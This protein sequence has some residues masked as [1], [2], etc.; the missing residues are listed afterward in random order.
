MQ[1]VL[2]L[3]P[4]P[5]K[6]VS[7]EQIHSSIK[8]PISH[9]KDP[10]LPYVVINTVTTLDGKTSW[11]GKSS[12]IGSDVDRRVMRTIRS[13]VDAVLVG[14][15]TVRAE[16]LSLTVPADLAEWRERN[17]EQR[18]PLAVVLS[19]KGDIHQETLDALSPNTL[20]LGNE[21]P[22][23]GTA[24]ETDIRSYLALLKNEHGVERLLVEG[25]PTVNHSLLEVGLVNELFIT[26]SPKIHGGAE[27]NLV[28]GSH[29][30]NKEHSLELV[31]TFL[32]EQE[33]YLRYKFNFR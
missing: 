28:K 2:R 9:T 12:G 21:G 1:K 27:A 18:Q 26:L 3:L 23:I 4:G 5:Q 25:G 31:S 11:K 10:E 7:A 29:L 30:K 15:G 14:A 22:N 19:R 32:C 13:K 6:E 33:L 16:R 8:F 20:I 24:H 17:G